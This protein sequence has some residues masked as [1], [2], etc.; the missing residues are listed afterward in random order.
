MAM[1]SPLSLINTLWVQDKEKANQAYSDFMNATH[2]RSLDGLRC[3]SILAV[4]WHHAAGDQY[5]SNS[6][7]FM[8]HH[9]VTLF[10]VISGFLITSLLLR[11]KQS[12]RK[13]S[14]YSFY[15]RRTLRIFPLYYLVLLIYCA[16]VFLL[17]RNSVAG[18][19]F[20]ENVIYFA[21][22]TS[23]YFVQL[24]G[25]RVIFYFAWSLAA[26]EQFYMVWPAIE[27]WF[28]ERFAVLTALLAIL[29]SMLAS[30]SYLPLESDS[31]AVIILRNIAIPIC[32]GVLLAHLMNNERFFVW[33]Y[34]FA[35]GDLTPYCALVLA[36]YLFTLPAQFSLA[37]YLLLGVLIFCV[38]TRSS[39]LFDRVLNT[40]WVIA[41]GKVS[42]GMYLF[43]MLALNLNRRLLPLDGVGDAA[44]LEQ[45]T[46]FITS[47]LLTF[48]IAQLSFRYF[49]SYF[50]NLKRNC[51]SHVSNDMKHSIKKT[52]GGVCHAINK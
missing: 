23:N 16:L 11:E 47:S 4:I 38:V 45:F 8:G 44:A 25:D 28:S 30:M 15:L 27:K 3:L 20:F 40:G 41:I 26:E 14:L 34:R 7:L 19:S 37:A 43:H 35:E 2:F 18:A 51:R 52:D 6:L 42:Y 36:V 39:G 21:T 29:I 50:L 33:L 1:H 24:N 12:T 22:Y 17:E 9:G 10:F 49:E 32:I 13:I 31:L 46:L 48:A 5:A